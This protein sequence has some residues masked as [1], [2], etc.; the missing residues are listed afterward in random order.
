MNLTDFKSFDVAGFDV[1]GHK[2]KDESILL[3]SGDILPVAP[4]EITLNNV[5][6]TLENVIEGRESE[7]GIFVNL[8]YV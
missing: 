4:K 8:Q 2:Q 7:K 5:Q 3:S 6:Y 1:A